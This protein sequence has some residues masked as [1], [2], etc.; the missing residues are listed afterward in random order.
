M[1]SIDPNVDVIGLE[2]K[3]WRA[4]AEHDLETALELTDFP[5]LIASAQ[6][7][8]SVNEEEFKRVFNSHRESIDKPTIGDAKTR[9]LGPDTAIVAYEV[10]CSG[11]SAVDTSTWVRRDGRW[12]CAMHTEIEAEETAG[13]HS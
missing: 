5:C 6:G 4:M 8:R 9:M 3:Y 13:R 10:Q 12:V 1:N 2:K 7:V 11:K